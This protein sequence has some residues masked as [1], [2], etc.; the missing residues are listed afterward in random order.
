M[1]GIDGRSLFCLNFWFKN[2]SLR[3]C[4]V[5]GCLSLWGFGKGFCQL[6]FSRCNCCMFPESPLIFLCSQFF[7]AAKTIHKS[8]A[9]WGWALK[10]FS[11]ST[12][13]LFVKIFIMNLP[14]KFKTHNTLCLS[15]KDKNFFTQSYLSDFRKVFRGK[16]FPILAIVSVSLR[17]K[18]KF[19]SLAALGRI[20]AFY[21][22]RRRCFESVRHGH[23]G[24]PSRS[25]L[26]KNGAAT[27]P[28]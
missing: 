16:C 10:K 12:L 1:T 11:F 22:K 27:T 18:R 24:S 23:R 19:L 4:E 3:R 13:V 21:P 20:L 2:T 15:S 5:G 7:F 6:V 25:N 14:Q 28:T 26:H 8:S 9:K 17:C